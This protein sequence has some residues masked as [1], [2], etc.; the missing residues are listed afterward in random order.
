LCWDCRKV[1]ERKHSAVSTQQFSQTGQ[2]E[3]KEKG[4]DETTISDEQQGPGV[5]E[6]ATRLQISVHLRKSAV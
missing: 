4:A 2:P 5:I 1:I 6:I 3:T